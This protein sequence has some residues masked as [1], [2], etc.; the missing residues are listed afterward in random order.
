MEKEKINMVV[1]NDGYVKTIQDLGIE[2]AS[3]ILRM[4]EVL[5]FRRRNFNRTTEDKIW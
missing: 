4:K 3:V 1:K 5:Q 2:P